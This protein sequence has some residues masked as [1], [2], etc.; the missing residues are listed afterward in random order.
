ME[1]SSTRLQAC[2]IFAGFCILFVSF[3][4]MV[5]VRDRHGSLILPQHM[6][7]EHHP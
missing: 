4:G 5:T 1:K 7:M 3:M 2:V 6:L